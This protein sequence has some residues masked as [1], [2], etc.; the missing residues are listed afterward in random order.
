MPGLKPRT[1]GLVITAGLVVLGVAAFGGTTIGRENPIVP[2][3]EEEAA[4]FPR[5]GVAAT[6]LPLDS[7]VALSVTRALPSD[8]RI[9]SVVERVDTTKDDGVDA[10]EVST[11]EDRLGYEVTVYRNFAVEE[12]VGLSTEESEGGHVWIAVTDRDLTSIYYLSD[13]GVG[14]RVAHL[15]P[16][17]PAQ[18]DEL[19]SIAAAL[20]SDP[21]VVEEAAK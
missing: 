9:A 21:V 13:A 6:D 16:E 4:A 18:V 15:S 14:L 10:V 3:G 12:M 5:E 1:L 11:V 8:S 7:P 2:P 20:A 19:E 17:A